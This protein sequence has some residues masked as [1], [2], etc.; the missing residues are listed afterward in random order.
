MRRS[1]LILA[2]MVAAALAVA[3]VAL[4]EGPPGSSPSNPITAPGLSPSL[5]LTSFAIIKWADGTSE[6][7]DLPQEVVTPAILASTIA[8]RARAEGREITDPFT[9]PPTRT[10]SSTRFTNRKAIGAGGGASACGGTLH[11]PGKLTASLVWNYAS[12]TCTPDVFWVFGTIYLYRSA[13]FTQI[14]YGS[15]ANP[16]PGAA[17]SAT[18]SC[19]P[20]T[21][22]YWSGISWGFTGAN[23]SVFAPVSY[24]GPSWI[25]C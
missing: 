4:A 5:P 6:R 24:A 3:G 10:I 17:W 9:A 19:A 25:S 2:G 20:S 7:V 16:G 23:G 12:V 18:G 11:P 14:G 1:L 22:Q 15:N 21:W 13:N 8:D